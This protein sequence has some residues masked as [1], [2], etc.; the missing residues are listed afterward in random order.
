MEGNNMKILGIVIAAAVSIIVL[1]SV[2][3]PVFND[4]SD[5]SETFTNDGYVKLS[6]IDENT[7]AS[8]SWDHTNPKV[9]VCNGVPVDMSA[10]PEDMQISVVGAD[11]FVVRYENLAGNLSRLIC[12]G[13]GGQMLIISSGEN[14]ATMSINNGVFSVDFG[15]GVRTKTLN[16]GYYVNA[17]G[18]YVLKFTDSPAYVSDDTL[19]LAGITSPSQSVSV[20]VF[21]IGTIRSMEITPTFQTGYT[22]K[23]IVINSEA[24]SG[25]DDLHK[26]S[27]I[28]FKIVDDATS[29]EYDATYSYFA[30]PVNVVVHESGTLTDGQLS[31]LR[32]IPVMII[33][34]ILMM[35]VGVIRSKEI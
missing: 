4:V 15:S 12:N 25:Y 27:A 9:I 24:V 21:G 20:A 10:I 32:A 5:N 1:G 26:L 7:T 2:L 8:F 3:M 14:N 28:T 23:N 35:V 33:I 13:V 30:V 19:V 22:I 17:L 16:N 34:G 18:D 6:L 29:E 31:L 11:S